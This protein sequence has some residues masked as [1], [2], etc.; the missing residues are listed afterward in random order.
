MASSSD[1]KKGRRLFE[2]FVVAGLD[3]SRLEPLSTNAQECGQRNAQPLAPITDITVIFPSLGE[4]CPDGFECLSTTTLGYPADLNHGSLRVPQAFI[5]FRRG[6]HKPPL[7]DVGV[8]DKG[9]GE[10]PLVDIN[11]VAN[12][13]FG[14]VANVNNASQPIFLTY[15]RASPDAPP[16]QL[17]VT[18]LL[19]TLANKGEVPPHTYYKI[20]HNLNKGIMGSDVYLCYKKSQGTCKR[21]AYK[22]RVLDIFP[23]PR[24]SRPVPIEKEKEEQDS[25]LASSPPSSAH[26][27]SSPSLA[28]SPPAPIT[29][30]RSFSTGEEPSLIDNVPMFCLPMGAAIECWPARCQQPDKIFSTFVLTDEAGTKYY[31]ASV[32]FYELH[33]GTLTE[34]QK[35]ILEIGKEEDDDNSSTVASTV[36]DNVSL[37]DPA[38]QLRFYINCS[39]CIVSKYPFFTAFKRFLFHIHR[40]SIKSRDSFSVPIE[41]Y[42]T[43]LM[44]EVTFPTPRRPRVLMHLPAE[45]ITFECYDDS[46]LPLTGAALF[47]TL[48]C[49]GPDTLMYLMMLALLEQRILIHSLR[50]HLLTV[51][52]ESVLALMFPF[53]WQC[54]YVPQCPLALAGVVHAPV[55]FIAGVDSRYFELFEEPPLEVTCFDLDTGTISPSAV[56]KSMKLGMMPKAATKQ[57]KAT[58]EA[59]RTELSAEDFRVSKQ[60]SADFVPVDM[61]MAIQKKRKAIESRIQEAWIRFMAHVM[62]DYQRHLR[63]ITSAPRAHDTDTAK[64]FDKEAFLRSRDKGAAEFYKRFADTQLFD[65]FIQ[66]RCFISDK[67]AYDAF[68]DDCIAKVVMT[69]EH[70]IDPPMP[71]LDCGGV[72]PSTSTSS[73]DH[74]VF[75]APPE[76]ILDEKGEE[77]AFV[78]EDGFPRKL[79]DSLFQLDKLNTMNRVVEGAI[80]GAQH[81]E[82]RCVCLR[83]KPEVR[84]SL[85]AA[86][87]GVR[88]NTANWAKTV[89]FYAYSLWFLTLP[90]AMRVS[91]N[92]KKTM[93]TAFHVLQR[94]EN[95]EVFP[96]DQVCFRI[97]ISLCGEEQQAA[98]AVRVHQAMRRQAIEQNAV[99]YGVYHRVVMNAKWPSPAAQSASAAWTRVRTMLS[100]VARLRAV[101]ARRYGKPPSGSGQVHTS[102]VASISD[103]GY[104]S[105]IQAVGNNEEDSPV[106]GDEK[107]FTIEY[108]PLPGA[109]ADQNEDFDPL[110]AMS[111]VETK[112]PASSVVS[113]SRARFLE[114][115]KEERQLFAAKE[116][117]VT[118]VAPKKTTS[119]SSWFKGITNS[120]IV[121]MIKSSTFDH[122]TERKKS[123]DAGSTGSGERSSAGGL[124][125]PSMAMSPSLH[126]LVGNLKK[127]YD[128]VIKES[129][130]SGMNTLVSGLNRSYGATGSGV[131]YGDEE[132]DALPDIDYYDPAYW[133]D[134]ASLSLLPESWWMAGTVDTDARPSS[135]GDDDCDGLVLEVTMSSCTKCP[136]CELVVYDEDVMAGW[137]VDDQTLQTSCP[138][139]S[140]EATAAAAAI[141]S[142]SSSAAAAAGAAPPKSGQFVP[143]LRIR[144]RW[145]PRPVSSWYAPNWSRSEEQRAEAGNTAEMA[146]RAAA[147]NA[148]SGFSEETH[149][150]VSPLVLRRELESLLAA[151]IAALADRSLMS[152]HPVI[153]WNLVYYLKRLNLPSHLYSWLGSSVQI[154]CV[155]DRPDMHD[156]IVPLYFLNP[157]NSFINE[158]RKAKRSQAVWN[159]VTKSVAENRLFGALQSIINEHRKKTES[160]VVLAR[161]F[162]FF[163]DILFTSLN[164][165]GRSLVRDHLDMSYREEMHRLPPRFAPI[166]PRQDQPQR[167]VQRACRKVFF[168][169]DLY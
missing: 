147:K 115:H 19:V 15:R 136:D 59:I 139:C 135:D 154:R 34:E 12:T 148:A 143:E 24:G 91:S 64:L 125:A 155:F 47:D 16:S 133:I 68:F 42:I 95:T 99:T 38:D 11:T 72:D 88:T 126:S 49:L 62:R 79:D 131:L 149:K 77:R 137:R 23:R 112:T 67:N 141:P 162:P 101:Y 25:S 7:I 159:E 10:K 84:S 169:L 167:P 43:H 164:Q 106:L 52:A 114:E 118:P 81:A 124:S 123:S 122:S 87:N 76:P 60:Y 108:L 78:Y 168:P 116:E 3:E 104:A 66:E 9:R 138:Y 166:L 157:N 61:D 8:L 20:P 44:Y 105:D 26:F 128:N 45:T 144:R 98:Q 51:V 109:A 41:R 163:R 100:A 160:T 39:I 75:I 111:A 83:T 54:P 14:R 90:S 13:P 37:N 127:G 161:H 48:K 158:D 21:I 94:M 145:L 156:D 165:F 56:R 153:Y 89:Q 119:S 146:R 28:S 57:L 32:T 74:G 6:F 29:S 22:P 65:R 69:E 86:R 92:R 150:L 40:M 97:V 50:P 110:S 4:T 134:S 18:H 151:D 1:G 73:T 140:E 55:P 71:L 31:G 132:E 96:L 117:V 27:A 129:V 36:E 142:T 103:N 70:R 120:P 130:R 17:V 82:S 33:K 102:E 113:P 5:C 85:M 107:A 46:Q 121:R 152:S 58:L 80:E 53:H 63:P 93:R 2:Y 35:E 30:P